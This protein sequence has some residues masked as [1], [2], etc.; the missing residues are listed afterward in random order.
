MIEGE[1]EPP[2]QEPHPP[3]SQPPYLPF[4]AYAPPSVLVAPP[5]PRWTRTYELPTARRVVS[6][7]LQLA[8]GSRDEIRRASIYIGLLM[9]LALV[10]LLAPFVLS[11]T[12]SGLDA[13]Q[14]VGLMF[15]NPAYLSLIDPRLGTLAL[16]LDAGLLVSVVLVFAVTIDA[17]GMAISVLAGHATDNRLPIWQALVRARQVFWRLVGASLLVGI[18]GALIGFVV[19]QVLAA[20]VR[21]PEATQLI[22]QIVATLL[23]A[24]FV[25]VTTGIVIGDVGVFAAIRRSMRLFRARPRTGLVVVLFP[26]VTSAIQVFALLAGVDLVARLAEALKFDALTGGAAVAVAIVLVVIAVVAFGS[27]LLTIAAIVAAP[28]VAAFLGLTLYAGGIA[29]VAAET[30]RPSNVRWVT[31]KMLAS[32]AIPTIGVLVAVSAIGPMVPADIVTPGGLFGDAPGGGPNGTTPLLEFLDSAASDHNAFAYSTEVPFFLEDAP[33]DEVG[34]TISSADIV[35]VEFGALDVMPRWLLS[36]VF[37]C[38]LDSVTCDDRAPR[39]ASYVNG[40]VIVLLR[41]AGP[42]AVVESGQ[43]GEWGAVFT[44]AGDPTAPAELGAP[45][46][47]A[48]HAIVTSVLDGGIVIGSRVYDGTAVRSQGTYARSLRLENDLIMLIPIAEELDD[49]PLQWDVY[50]LITMAAGGPVS[51]DSLR[52]TN[53]GRGLRAYS[54]PPYYE[55]EE[56]PTQP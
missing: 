1:G 45:I 2:P 47:A 34:S 3:P 41:T 29:R 22:A 19:G 26:L 49:R 25:Y 40:A 9:L 28:Q 30:P 52:T 33:G 17:Q 7:G 13:E 43:R 31:R 39:P 53:D 46:S 24:P 27:L 21:S 8:V 38:S 36:D 23:L 14:L 51:R 15:S 5:R 32:V 48:N 10:P 55:F 16:I 37:D 54:Q 18:A 50:S 4:A 35:Y 56:I 20:N 12:G 6:A 42:A 11:L 44:L